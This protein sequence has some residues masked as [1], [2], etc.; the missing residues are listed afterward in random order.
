MLRHEYRHID[1]E[2]LWSVIT[3]HLDSLDNAAA[4]LM[5]RLRDDEY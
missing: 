2:I 4:Q 1:P 3:E 5:E